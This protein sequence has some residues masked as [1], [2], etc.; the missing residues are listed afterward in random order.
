MEEEL[1]LLM[2]Q[3]DEELRITYKCEKG[4]DGDDKARYYFKGQAKQLVEMKKRIDS[5]YV[6]TVK[7]R[8]HDGA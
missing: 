2:A 1:L 8:R 3:L 5:L 4:A 7:Q 6:A